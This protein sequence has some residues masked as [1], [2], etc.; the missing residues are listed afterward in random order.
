MSLLQARERK[1]SCSDGALNSR[2]ILLQSL[3]ANPNNHDNQ[4]GRKSKDESF[5]YNNN[6]ND[7]SSNDINNNNNKI[8]QKRKDG[9]TKVP[10]MMKGFLGNSERKRRKKSIISRILSSEKEELPEDISCMLRY[11]VRKFDT[12]RVIEL[13]L[14]EKIN[15]DA[16]NERGVTALHEAGIDGNI[17]CMKVLVNHGAKINE[18]DCEGFTP[19][20]YAVFAGNFE[21]AAYL[22]EKGAKEDRIRDGQIVYKEPPHYRRATVS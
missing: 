22:I 10:E 3:H 4:N 14:D 15:I 18:S 9:I 16:A 11:A 5:K 6:S 12:E 7:S 13:V 20:D 21:C 19:L 8:K 17:V 2:N 1:L